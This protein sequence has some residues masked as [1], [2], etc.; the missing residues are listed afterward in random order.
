MINAAPAGRADDFSWPRRAPAPVGAD[1]VVATTT[2]PMTPML[3]S[4]GAAQQKDATPA[5][6][7]AAAAAAAARARAQQAA[8][9]QRA[10]VAQS[11]YRQQSPFFFF[12]G[13]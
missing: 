2:L 6:A 10:R 7:A 8:A 11:P 3:A 12:F 9:R 4:S 13:R 1:P 5:P